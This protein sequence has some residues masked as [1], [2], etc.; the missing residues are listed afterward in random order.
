MK[1]KADKNILNLF[2]YDTKLWSVKVFW[3]FFNLYILVSMEAVTEVNSE[4][5]S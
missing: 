4:V 5:F 1:E 3:I 2:Q